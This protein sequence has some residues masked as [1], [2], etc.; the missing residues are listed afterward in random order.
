M[1]L[2]LQLLAIAIGT[3]LLWTSVVDLSPEWTVA[4]IVGRI[5]FGTLLIV[6]GTIR[7][8]KDVK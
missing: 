8:F 3:T 7:I 2:L 1:R 4:E 6:L 5:I